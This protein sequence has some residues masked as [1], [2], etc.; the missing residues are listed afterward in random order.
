VIAVAIRLGAGAA[1]ALAAGGPGVVEIALCPGGY[2]LLGRER[3]LLV[4]PERAPLGPLSVLVRGLSPLRAGAPVAHTGAAL[5]V[6]DLRID[7][8]S[9]RADGPVAPVPLRGAWRLALDAA[10]AECPSPPNEL[11]A[12]LEALREGAVGVLAGLGPGLTPAG[13]DVLAGYAAWQHADGAQVALGSERCS[14]LGRAY[15]RCA[16]RGELPE[17]ASRVLYA[18]RAGDARVAARRA[19]A[20][21]GWGATSGSAILWGMAAAAGTRA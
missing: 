6:G 4:A 21:S 15:L 14:P 5:G 1:R 7:L 10:L 12:G 19:R 17:V 9:A 8:R 16:E 13:D 3:W 20:L 11:A 18:I 2:V